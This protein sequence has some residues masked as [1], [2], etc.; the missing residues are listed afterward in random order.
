VAL[1][2]IAC[3][4]LAAR[5][6]AGV[7][8]SPID[9]YI[10]EAGGRAASGV[11]PSPGSLFVSTARLADAARDMRA[12]Q[13][14]DVVTI[15]VSDRAS[16]LAKGTVSSARKS[17]TKNSITTLLGQPSPV[18]ALANL[19]GVSG[20]TQLTGDAQTSRETLLT[21]TITARVTHVL[22]NGN[23]VLEAAK[24]VMIN[25][26]RQMISVR[27]VVRPTDLS[28]FNQ[29][30]SDR[31]AMLEIRVNG[32]GVVGDAI[33]RPAIFYRILLGLLPF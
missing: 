10:L 4:P 26:E 33:R 7:E 6:P 12:S 11:Q 24:D 17:S 9:R 14:D 28:S 20:D 3:L 25:S 23:L 16:A 30:R 31:L 5:K 19:A 22:A 2:W 27:G 29:V 21:T 15:V 18:G 13:V 8:P 32:K 1:I